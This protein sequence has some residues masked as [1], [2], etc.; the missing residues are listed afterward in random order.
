MYDIRSDYRAVLEICA[1]LADPELE[2]QDKAVVALNIFYPAFGEM[3]SEHYEKALKKCFWFIGCGEEGRKHHKS[4]KLVDWEQDFSYIV[5]PI[6]RVLGREIRS[7]EYIH[8]WTFIAAYYEI[9]DCTFAQIVRIRSL[10]KKGKKLDKQDRE[11]YQQ[12]RYLVDWKNT[13]TEK[14]DESLK[15]WLKG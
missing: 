7:V 11:W 3:P 2:D 4:P 15:Q 9:G 12:N 5:A 13:Y 14:E 8:W 10:L 1:A 6:N